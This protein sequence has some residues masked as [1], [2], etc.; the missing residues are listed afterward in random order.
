MQITAPIQP[1]VRRRVV[2][3]T[4]L[5]ACAS[6]G[7]TLF[8]RNSVSRAADTA[9]RPVKWLAF[10]GQSADER[11]LGSYDIV[12]LDPMFEG[13]LQEIGRNGTRLCGYLSLG[14]V[15]VGDKLYANVDA[16]ALLEQ[17]S[18]WPGTYRVDV[19]HPSW[20]K[21]ILDE[22]IPFIARRGFNGLFLDT[23]DTPPYLEQ[24]DPDSWHGMRQAAIDLVQSI[25][26]RNTDKFIIINR[27]Y[28][29]LPEL[30]G[31]M[32]AIVAESLLTAPDA[33]DS[34]GYKWESPSEIAQ[35]LSLLTPVAERKAQVPILSLDYWHPEDSVT[36][37]EIYARERL[38]GHH[39]YVAT[40][41]LDRIIPEPGE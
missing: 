23:L 38:L 18:A 9:S 12:V 7:V 36:I 2:R 16:A 22:V 35:V 13:S 5:Q 14:E 37:R 17:N 27:G 39:P 32:D 34:H 28:A 40:R 11:V 19:R 6:L 33:H 4:L 15:R 29:L 25:R 41:S 24:L 1:G 10:Y 3:R 8:L 21:L 31:S 26:K 30:I 20:K